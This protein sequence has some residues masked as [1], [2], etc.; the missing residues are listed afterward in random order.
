[1]TALGF[2][3]RAIRVGTNGLLDEWLGNSMTHRL[4]LAFVLGVVVTAISYA[5]ETGCSCGPAH[6]L[7][8]AYEH[9]YGGC[10]ARSGRLLIGAGDGSVRFVPVWDLNAFAYDVLAWG[11]L[12][13][14][15]LARLA[16]GG[17]QPGAPPNG[18]PATRP[19]AGDVRG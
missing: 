18:G 2:Q 14:I 4:L 19:A 5:A 11:A 6:G 16:E 7:P 1:M 17:A 10:C 3:V 12:G 9:P 13:F 8:F 15:A